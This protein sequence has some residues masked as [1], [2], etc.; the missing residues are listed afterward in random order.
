M[1]KKTAHEYY[2]RLLSF[3]QFVNNA[4]KNG[5][6]TNNDTESVLDNIIAN[7]KGGSEDAYDILS[8]FVTYLQLPISRMVKG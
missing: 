6:K 4:Y 7:I 1:N 3:R 5:T 2:F 8:D